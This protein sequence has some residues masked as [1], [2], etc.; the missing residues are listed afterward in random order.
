MLAEL[1]LCTGTL[2]YADSR[3]MDSRA[4]KRAGLLEEP[5]A[6]GLLAASHGNAS[7]GAPP[8]PSGAVSCVAPRLRG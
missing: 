3:G 4:K 2:D 7:A 8:P 5:A 6:A 1:L